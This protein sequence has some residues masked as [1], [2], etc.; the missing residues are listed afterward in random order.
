M[1]RTGSPILPDWH[2]TWA[3]LIDFGRQ[4]LECLF[5]P[6]GTPAAIVQEALASNESGDGQPGGAEPARDIGVTG[7]APERRSPEYLA[8]F[9]VDEIADGRS[10]SRPMV[11][12]D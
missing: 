4:Y 6:K 9:V 3:G 5:F 7:V 12:L 10:R 8:K 11:S 2:G 1:T